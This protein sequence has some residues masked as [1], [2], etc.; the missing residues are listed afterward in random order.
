MSDSNGIALLATARSGNEK[1]G[2]LKA[3]SPLLPASHHQGRSGSS[4]IKT[5]IA[6]EKQNN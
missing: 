4:T 3:N 5:K 2:E 1:R 6:C